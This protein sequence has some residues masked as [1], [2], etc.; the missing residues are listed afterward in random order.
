[1]THMTLHAVH[2][3]IANDSYAITFQSV[4]QY[5]ATL[6]RHFDNL[7]DG[8][9]RYATGGSVPGGVHLVGDGLWSLH[10]Y[11][12]TEPRGAAVTLDEALYALD[13]IVNKMHVPGLSGQ[14]AFA[15]TVLDR[16]ARINGGQGEEKL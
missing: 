2:Q 11:A 7:V 6:L 10:A 4:E 9:P 16:A 3:L 1:M 14:R 12:G 13:L 8:A 15:L 5:R